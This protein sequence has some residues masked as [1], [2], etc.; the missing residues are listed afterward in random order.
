MFKES[1]DDTDRKQLNTIINVVVKQVREDT[2][3]QTMQD[4]MKIFPKMMDYKMQGYMAAQEFWVN[5]NDL[6]QFC[7]KYPKIKQYVQYRSTEIQRQNPNH[8][9]SQVFKE[10]EKEVRELLKDR[11]TKM[12]AQADSDGEGAK[13]KPGLVRKPGAGRKT[14]A[15]KLKR[16]SSE[17]EQILELINYDK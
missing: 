16:N 5:N 1:F 2:R 8:T 4:A 9:L 11:L 17:Q 7:E 14:P 15:A 10:T 3:N 6:K 13:Q 12:K